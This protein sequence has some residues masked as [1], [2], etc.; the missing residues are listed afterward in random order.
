MKYFAFVVA[1]LAFSIE[2]PAQSAF[3]KGTWIGEDQSVVYGSNPHHPTEQSAPVPRVREFEFT[4]VVTGQQGL[5]ERRS[6]Q[7]ALR[8]VAHQQWPRRHRRRH[9]RLLPDNA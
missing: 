5:L 8:L 3:P 7:R 9:R 4:M 1:L 6:D 2:V